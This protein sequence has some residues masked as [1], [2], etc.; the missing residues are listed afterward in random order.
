LS[1]R[2]FTDRNGTAWVVTE[3]V[4]VSLAMEPRERRAQPRSQSRPSAKAKRLSTRTL[5]LAWLRFESARETRRLSKFPSDWRELP[6]DELEDLL[7]DT[8]PA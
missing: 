7:A 8:K 4:D 3:Q 5:E 1:E 2:R 6:E